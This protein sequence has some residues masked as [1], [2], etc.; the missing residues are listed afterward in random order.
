MCLIPFRSLSSVLAISNHLHWDF[1]DGATKLTLNKNQVKDSLGNSSGGA[2]V[3]F[4]EAPSRE[5]TNSLGTGK[6]LRTVFLPSSYKFRTNFQPG[7]CS[8]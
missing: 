2:T 3:A 4:L 8:P 6:N 5:N 1:V 7:I